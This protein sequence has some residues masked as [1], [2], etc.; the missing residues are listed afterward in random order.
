MQ[1][2]GEPG[3]KEVLDTYARTKGTDFLGIKIR[4]KVTYIY[5]RIPDRCIRQ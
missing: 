1:Y 4:T 2:G 3:I 5:N